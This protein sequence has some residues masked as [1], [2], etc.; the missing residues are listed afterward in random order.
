MKTGELINEWVR[1]TNCTQ[2][3]ITTHGKANTKLDMMYN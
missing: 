1:A 2:N 3:R